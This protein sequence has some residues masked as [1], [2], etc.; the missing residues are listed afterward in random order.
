MNTTTIRGWSRDQM[1]ARAAQELSDGCNVNLGIGIPTLLANH[2]PP[3]MNVT[4]QSENGML[5]MGPYPFDGEADP[6]L[7]NASKE[8]ITS[9]VVEFPAPLARQEGRPSRNSERFRQWLSVV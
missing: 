1:A 6:D 8:T 3:G 7:I 4:L 9:L 5:G 2:L